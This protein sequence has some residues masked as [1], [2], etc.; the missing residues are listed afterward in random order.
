[1]GWAIVDNT[2]GED[3]KEVKA[4]VGSSS[5]L[6]FRFDLWSI[7]PREREMQTSHDR[8]AVA[9]PTGNSPYGDGDADGRTIAL[10]DDELPRPDSHPD[11]Q[12]EMWR[13]EVQARRTTSSSGTSGG[14]ASVATKLESRPPPA[15][16]QK[17]DEGK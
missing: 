13:D 1:Q 6:S 5:A 4:G 12:A 10:A 16:N 2:S 15:R 17:Q 9:P 7:L 3:W 11:G 14:H 8:F